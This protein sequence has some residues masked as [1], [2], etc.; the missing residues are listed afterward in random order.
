MTV[1]M[2]HPKAG[3]A[4]MPETAVGWW[5]RL[6][7]RRIKA[8]ERSESE[9]TEPAHDEPNSHARPARRHRKKES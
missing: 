4:E 1:R 7:W 5:E 9:Q 8:Q 6:G 2:R 3:E